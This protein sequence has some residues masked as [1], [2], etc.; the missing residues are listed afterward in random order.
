[1]TDRTFVL[2]SGAWHGG[3]VWSGIANL[4]RRCGCN[5][6]TPTLTGLGDRRHVLADQADLSLHIEDV[7]SHIEM[8][9]LDNIDLLGWSYGGMVISGVHS[10]IPHKIRS[11]VFLDAFAPE[12]D[13]A[14]VDYLGRENREQYESAR[15][16]DRTIEP[17]PMAAFG[18]TDQAVLDFVEP[19]ICHQPWRTFFEPAKVSPSIVDV[20]QTYIHCTKWG[21]DSPMTQFLPLMKARG[22]NIISITGSHLSMLTEAEE[23][24]S[25]I[26]STP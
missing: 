24:L 9:G 13:M 11:L 5:V 26:L 1:M 23:T 2:V 12:N 19:R 7:V 21:I 6:T 3:W 18:V 25:A 20:N 16:A 17:I 14:L 10:R 22:A 15:N 8:E 4:L